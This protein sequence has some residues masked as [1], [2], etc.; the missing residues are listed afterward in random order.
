MYADSTTLNYV[1]PTSRPKKDRGKETEIFSRI[2]FFNAKKNCL[3]KIVI[4]Q[5]FHYLR[6]NVFSFLLNFCQ[7]KKK[8]SIKY[9]YIY[10]RDDKGEKLEL[11]TPIHGLVPL[12]IHYKQ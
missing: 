11:L 2:R 7:K 5:N 3:Y 10:F 8:S 12:I 1:R 9:F 6:K 4:R